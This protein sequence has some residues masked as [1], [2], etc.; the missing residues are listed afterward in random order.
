MKPYHKQP[1]ILN[2]IG[3]LTAFC[4]TLTLVKINTTQEKKKKQ[5][6][7]TLLLLWRLVQSNLVKDS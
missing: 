7:E 3:S 5:G 4:V 6:Y 1:K 2:P